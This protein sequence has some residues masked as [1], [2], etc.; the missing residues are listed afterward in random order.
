MNQKVLESLAAGNTICYAP[1]SGG[2]ILLSRAGLEVPK[3]NQ[4]TMQEFLDLRREEKIKKVDT[5]TQGHHILHGQVDFYQIATNAEPKVIE[6]KIQKA[7][8]EGSDDGPRPVNERVAF[9]INKFEEGHYT[10]DDL[11]SMLGHQ[12]AWHPETRSQIP[13]SVTS[14]SFGTFT[15]KI[16]D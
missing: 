4:P 16:I 13:S 9:A 5:M 12:L 11:A 14:S 2:L 15:I 8:S 1:V 10:T 3:E 6:V 7:N